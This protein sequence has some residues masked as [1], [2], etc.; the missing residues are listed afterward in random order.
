MRPAKLIFS[1]TLLLSGCLTPSLHPLYTDTDVLSDP[2]LVGSWAEDDDDDD[3]SWTFELLEE[4]A[5]RLTITE[6]G[7]SA[8]LEAHLL[9]L[10]E[11]L[12]L[13]LYPEEMEFASDWYELHLLP[14]H[15]FYWV[16]LQG[17][18]LELAVMDSEWLQDR[19]DA[20]ELG[21]RHERRDDTVILTAPTADLQKFIL[22]HVGALFDYD[23]AGAMHRLD[24]DIPLIRAASNGQKDALRELLDAGRN[25]EERDGAG[26]TPLIWAARNGRQAAIRMLLDAG[27]DIEA[28][29]ARGLT[30]LIWAAKNG[31]QTEEHPSWGR[32]RLAVQA[33]LDA[34]ADIE[35]R[36][37]RGFTP[38]I[39]A[40]RNGHPGTVRKL[41][42]AG[43]DTTAR[44]AD[45]LTPLIWAARNGHDE[46]LKVLQGEDMEK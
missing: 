1:L 36:D 29:D 43:A 33:L 37:A 26:H 17:D 30:P 18:L 39:W 12:F 42:D 21:I 24:S 16:S 3:E 5:Y 28:R 34:G 14:V 41:L 27:A 10:G 4:N 45:G 31:H 20:G 9:Q 6:D 8:I 22:A 2:G 15:T 23:N 25:L 19:S 7:E 44:D 38:L 11:H 13:D 40:A 32:S 35:A 46:V